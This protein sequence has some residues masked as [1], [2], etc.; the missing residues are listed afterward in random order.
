MKRGGHADQLSKAH[1][2]DKYR[3]QALKKII[4]SGQLEP[5]SYRAAVRTLQEKCA[6][7]ATGCRKRGKDAE[8]RYFEDLARRMGQSA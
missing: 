8:A 5:D 6:I 3:I 2:L 4:A 7:F 1:G